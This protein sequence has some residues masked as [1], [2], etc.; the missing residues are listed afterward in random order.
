[1][2]DAGVKNEEAEVSVHGGDGRAGFDRD[3]GL[4]AGG[5]ELVEKGVLEFAGRLD[6]VLGA[7]EDFGVGNVAVLVYPGLGGLAVGGCAAGAEDDAE[8][9][10]ERELADEGAEIRDGRV[11]GGVFE[12]L[13]EVLL[14]GRPGYGM[15]SEAAGSVGDDVVDADEDNGWACL[16]ICGGRERL[17][18]LVHGVM[19][20]GERHL[21]A[22]RVCWV[23]GKRPGNIVLAQ[24]RVMTIREACSGRKGWAEASKR[25]VSVLQGV[26]ERSR[27]LG[28]GQPAARRGYRQQ[29]WGI[30]PQVSGGRRR[31][32]HNAI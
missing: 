6:V 25:D 10:Q 5:V 23:L 32:R 28:A 27:R 30:E 13:G 24:G 15:S 4:D 11:L 18:R 21:R 2:K 3:G 7:H 22:G 20:L 26:L 31:C 29:C 9:R 8:I 1:M 17:G 14:G 16:G 12:E 19:I